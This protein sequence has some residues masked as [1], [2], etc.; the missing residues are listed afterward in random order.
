M[1]S[2]H[3]AL[4]SRGVNRKGILLKKPPPTFE[5]QSNCTLRPFR[6]AGD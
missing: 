4:N 3:G 5:R 1:A 2:T 6:L